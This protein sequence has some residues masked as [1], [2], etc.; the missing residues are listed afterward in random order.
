VLGIFYAMPKASFGCGS[1]WHFQNKVPVTLRPHFSD[2]RGWSPAGIEETQHMEDILELKDQRSHFLRS[3]EELVA[4]AE[5]EN[6]II[7]NEE[8]EAVDELTAKVKKLDTQIAAIVDHE[9][10]RQK[11]AEERERIS[12]PQGRVSAP[13]QPAE[14]PRASVKTPEIVSRRCGTLQ[15]FKGP[16]AEL[17]AYQ[18]G[19][20]LID[21][22]FPHQHPMKFKAERYC[23]EHIN[24]SIQGALG[25]GVP[26]SGGNL[27]P[28][29]MS[30]AIIDLREQYGIGRQW[31]DVMPMSTDIQT[32]PRRS[33]SPTASFTSEN[34]AI[35]ESEPTF[36][37][38][39]FTAKKLAVLT[40]I[41]TE[42]S[43]DSVINIAD[44]LT[45]D[46]AWAF[47]LKE[48]QCLFNGDGTST[49]GGIIGLT[50][51]A[52]YTSPVSYAGSYIVVPTLTHNTFAELDNTDLTTLMAALPQYA[53]SGGKGCAWF[54]SQVAADIVFGRLKATAGGNT[55]DT[56]AG[57]GITSLGQRGV[58]GTYLGYPIVASQVLPTS[59]GALTSVPML[60][61]GNLSLAA[62]IA[63]R[64]AISFA[65][66]PSLYFNYDQVAIRATSRVDIITHDLGDASTAGPIVVLKGGTS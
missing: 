25:T 45:K 64:R 60:A 27:V 53:R 48:D 55:L 61:F 51:K 50:V 36:N 20:W 47:A 42:L 14:G 9:N 15:A 46:I 24:P 34:S 6:R 11:L 58:V 57:A 17:D 62:T 23:R 12:G 19:M 8:K 40:R 38:V 52:T 49:Y 22:L 54:C 41:S 3:A 29:A 39:T 16:N 7:T 26:A 63:D 56:L 4:K 31:A 5:S 66:D 65:I 37:N 35:S 43:E 44:Y 18:T 10:Y 1:I 21:R 32:V 2:E 59:T 33:G 13:N 28:D 30:N